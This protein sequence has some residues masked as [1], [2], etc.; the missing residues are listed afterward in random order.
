VQPH[1]SLNHITQRLTK[2]IGVVI[3]EKKTD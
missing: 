1:Y 3:S 2:D